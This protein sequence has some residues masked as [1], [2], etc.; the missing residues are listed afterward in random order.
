MLGVAGHRLRIVDDQVG[1]AEPDRLFHRQVAMKSLPEVAAV[2]PYGH[3]LRL[4]DNTLHCHSARGVWAVANT[5][6]F[7]RGVTWGYYPCAPPEESHWP[8]TRAPHPRR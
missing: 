1:Q 7:W 5:G 6:A 2:L 4:R 8:A 3:R